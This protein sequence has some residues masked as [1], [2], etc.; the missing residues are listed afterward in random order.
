MH[1]FPK[2]SFYGL[3]CIYQN[4]S[5][6]FVNRLTRKTVVY[7]LFDNLSLGLKHL[8][9][10]CIICMIFICLPNLALWST[11]VHFF[12]LYDGENKLHSMSRQWVVLD[13]RAYLDLYNASSMKQHSASKHVTSLRRI[14]LIPSQP[15]FLLNAVC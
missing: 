1:S 6:S 13:Q 4:V 11:L 10:I 8:L 3:H 9:Y 12:Q 7:I 2:W 14:I 5:N 15:V